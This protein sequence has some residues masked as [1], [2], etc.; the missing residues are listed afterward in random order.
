MIPYGRQD[1]SRDDISSVSDALE[2]DWLT[3]GPR[4]QQFEKALE[5][6]TGGV[7]VV[8]VS[9][10]TAALHSA[11]S[12]I[13]VKPGDEIISPPLTFIATQAPSILLGATT[14]FADIKESDGN[15]DPEAVLAAISP[16]TVAIVAVDYAGHPA[17]L[18]ALRNIAD[19]HGLFLIEDAA[20]S[21]GS[22][23]H[24]NWVGSI[25]DFTTFSFFATKNITTGE[26]GAVAC[27]S[28]EHLN[29]VNKF[30]HQGLI[31]DPA[32]HFL[33]DEG[34]WHQ[35]VHKFGLNYRLTDIQA[36]LGSSQ[37][38]KLENF[39]RRRAQIKY[40]YDQI[41]LTT[42]IQVTVPHCESG[43][44][45]MWHLYPLR[46]PKELRRKVY[47]GLRAQGINVQVNYIPVYWHPVFDPDKYPRGLC[48]QTEEFYAQEISLPMHTRLTDSDVERIGRAVLAELKN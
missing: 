18:H 5:Q 6:Y 39:K 41:L 8:A 1:V 14:V 35:E 27:R 21:L 44:D 19:K 17:D 25:A 22:K 2:S 29:A 3:T 12:A 31:R 47:E 40:I 7:P 36:A 33:K 45:P 32:D 37:L 48:P 43:V 9:S 13:N 42:D 16:R 38:R 30:S 23:Y 24:D 46:V 11:F 34:P 10:G 4:V 26:G 28:I 20:H 15:I